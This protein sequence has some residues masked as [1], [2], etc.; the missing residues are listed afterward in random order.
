MA[1]QEVAATST[2]KPPTKDMKD[3]IDPDD[4]DTTIPKSSHNNP[5]EAAEFIKRVN[6]ITGTFVDNLSGLNRHALQENYMNFIH[7]LH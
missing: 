6:T 7:K 2:T 1:T 4:L 3:D 5:E